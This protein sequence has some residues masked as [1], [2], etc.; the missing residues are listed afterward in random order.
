MTPEE[1]KILNEFL[2]KTLKLDTEE[3]ATLYNEAGDLID[4]K[5][6][7]DA[8]S[9]RVRKQSEDRTSQYNRGLKEAATKL[10]KELKSK[11]EIESEL[12]GVDLV[13]SIVLAK[14]D[15]TK[16]AVKDISKHPEM[17][18][19]RAEWEKEQKKRDQ[20]WNDKLE[21]KDKEFARTVLM[22]KVKT[23]GAVLLEEFKPILPPE[24]EKAAMW[25]QVYLN[26][27][28]QF[29]YQEH[30]GDFIVKDKEGNPLK[31][32]H[33]YDRKFK[34]FSKEIADKYFSYEK[35]EQRSNSGN[36]D[37]S[38]GKAGLPKNEDEAYAELKNPTITPERRIEITNFLKEIQK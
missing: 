3:L 36:K 19:A 16:G 25:K 24:A 2:S 26:E 10:E 21:A 11:Y 14:V 32:A 5:P 34:E 17:L 35:A 7:Y 37:T 29:D 28:M 18:K 33:G 38:G 9:Y 20:E 27:L 13:D 1:K 31:D 30:D 22:D 4:L 23:K 8:D 15:E 12:Q 6:A